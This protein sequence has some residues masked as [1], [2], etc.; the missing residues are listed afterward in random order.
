MTS[1]QIKKVCLTDNK[2]ALKL[3]IR[4]VLYFILKT[5]VYVDYL[6]TNSCVQ[7]LCSFGTWFT[8]HGI[9]FSAALDLFSF[10]YMMLKSAF[11]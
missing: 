9:G 5:S 3:L 7:K 8:L 4:T 10:V 11:F 6:N 2:L 1:Y